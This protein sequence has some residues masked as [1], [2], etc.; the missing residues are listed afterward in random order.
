M[1]GKEGA[2]ERPN[3]ARD[4]WGAVVLA[5]GRSRR[6]GRLKAFLGWEGAPLIVHQVAELH[7][8][9]AVAIAVVTG[10]RA[11]R[12]ERCLQARGP[13]GVRCVLNPSA[14]H[15]RASSLRIGIAAL[16]PSLGAYLVAAVDQPLV[17][18]VVD[19]L[20]AER[21]A[22]PAAAAWLPAYRGRAGHPVL[23]AGRL[24]EELLRAD[25]AEQGL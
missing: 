22:D 12:L 17:A 25:D 8:A 16:P 11:A 2:A 3:G 13:A 23:C 6:M 15:G 5:A 14:D 19:A 9:G 21:A 18:A 24:R 4:A 7:R 20:L 1:K 10:F